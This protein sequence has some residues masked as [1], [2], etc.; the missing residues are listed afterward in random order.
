MNGKVIPG[1]S[2]QVTRSEGA[3]SASKTPAV[4]LARQVILGVGRQSRSDYT[5]HILTL[6]LVGR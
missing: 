3:G 2:R 5:Y 1:S 4:S 6:N